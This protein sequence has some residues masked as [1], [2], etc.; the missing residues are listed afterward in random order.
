MTTRSVGEEGFRWFIGIIED[1]NDPLELGRVRIRVINE[2][3]ENIQTDQIPW[4]QMMVPGTSAS[5]DGIGVAPVGAEVGSLAVGFFIDGNEKQFPMILGTFHVIPGMDKSKH[6]VHALARGENS[7]EKKTIG[8]E[9]KSAYKAEYPHNKVHYTKSGHAIEIDDTPGAERIHV[10]H[11]SGTY[12]EIN[13][14]GRLVTKV[15]GN[16]QEYVVKDKTLYVKGDVK[17]KIDG[18]LKA[19]VK[20]KTTVSG[21]EVDVNASGTVKVKGKKISLN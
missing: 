18:D 3:N 5:K 6:A 20:G 7:I 14:D 8:D 2:H 21:K 15:E 17:I 10:F 19:E 12:F 13:N 9:P 1:V 11:K 4:A 16:S